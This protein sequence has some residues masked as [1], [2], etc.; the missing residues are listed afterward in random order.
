MVT[1]PIEYVKTEMTK[2]KLRKFLIISES[3][4]PII[5]Y[6]LFRQI[7]ADVNHSKKISNTRFFKL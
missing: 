2:G 3:F 4:L 6:A 7:I 5:A 1:L